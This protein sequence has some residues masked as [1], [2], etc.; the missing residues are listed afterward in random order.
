LRGETEPAGCLLES[1]RLTPVV[2][3]TDVAYNRDV[4]GIVVGA[5]LHASAAGSDLDDVVHVDPG[6]TCLRAVTLGE[7]VRSWLNRETID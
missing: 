4:L 7:H 6:V 2:S 5:V 1:A 3:V